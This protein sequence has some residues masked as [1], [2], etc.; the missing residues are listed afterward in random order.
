MPYFKR[1]YKNGAVY[2]MFYFKKFY[3]FET[4]QD[5]T[6][7]HPYLLAFVRKTVYP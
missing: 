4:C 5:V 6:M 2:Q 3:L 7:Q 1:I